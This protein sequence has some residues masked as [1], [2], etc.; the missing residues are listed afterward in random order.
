MIREHEGAVLNSIYGDAGSLKNWFRD[1]EE[2]FTTPVYHETARLT[3]NIEDLMVIR[4][5]TSDREKDSLNTLL[6]DFKDLFAQPT[7]LP[8]QRSCDQGVNPVAVRPYRYRHLLK[9]EIERQCSDML[10]NGV[11]RASNSPFS[12]PVL[13]VKKADNSWRFCNDYR[14]L[15]KVT[16]KDK[17]PTPFVDELLDELHGARFSQNLI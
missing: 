14:E 17:F 8:P 11:I 10:R 3:K 15:N 12:S 7:S 4:T 16:I 5:M 13:L 9:D 2:I 1:E 6:G